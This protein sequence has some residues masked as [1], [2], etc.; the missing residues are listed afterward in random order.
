MHNISILIL[1]LLGGLSPYVS[2]NPNGH[3]ECNIQLGAEV[4]GL[5]NG[6][7]YEVR[8]PN[9][10]LDP[11]R[12][13]AT[14]PIPPGYE[15]QSIQ[16][17]SNIDGLT[18]L[19]IGIEHGHIVLSIDAD[20]SVRLNGEAL[21]GGIGIIILTDLTLESP[22][23][24]TSPPSEEAKGADQLGILLEGFASVALRSYH[25]WLP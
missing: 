17:E 14:A 16:V 13:I 8:A 22:N 24:E 12:T 9:V 1:L 5:A 11:G 7:L 23:P 2:P 15:I 4:P 21:A 10:A 6:Y 20:H 18:I 3:I 25:A 19:V